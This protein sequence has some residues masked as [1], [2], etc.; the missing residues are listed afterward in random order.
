[1]IPM[2]KKRQKTASKSASPGP[3]R[4]SQPAAAATAPAPA[5]VGHPPAKNPSLLAISIAL[6]AAWFVFLLITALWG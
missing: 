2:A 6:F 3:R 1:M 4:E 5:I